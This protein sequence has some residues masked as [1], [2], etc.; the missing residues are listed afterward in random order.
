MVTRIP[1]PLTRATWDNYMTISEADAKEKNLWLAQSTFFDQARHDANGGL[2]GLIAKVTVNG[3]NVTIPVMVQPGQAKGT[4]GIAFGYGRTSNIQ[5]ECKQEL[6][7]IHYMLTSTT[8]RIL[9]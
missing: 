3:A 1:D 7:H 9:P 6:M 2:N 8:F 4:V 5:K